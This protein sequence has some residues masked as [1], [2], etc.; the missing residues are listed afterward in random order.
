M[1]LIQVTWK[2]L[3]LHDQNL[4]VSKEKRYSRIE[5]ISKMKKLLRTMVRTRPELPR[6]LTTLDAT[7]AEW[8][9]KM[10]YPVVEYL[11]FSRMALVWVGWQVFY[12]Y[13]YP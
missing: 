3:N 9:D 13:N 12:L 2:L 8:E 11:R 5:S 1:D 4:P 10:I 7:D 6:E